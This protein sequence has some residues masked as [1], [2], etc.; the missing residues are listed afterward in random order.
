MDHKDTKTSKAPEKET[1]NFRDQEK[2]YYKVKCSEC[3]QETE[4]PFKPTEGRPV[5][6][7]ECYKK[8]NPQLSKP[9]F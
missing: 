1:K 7:R 2:T 3:S 9:R 6:C 8:K 5:Y 4:V